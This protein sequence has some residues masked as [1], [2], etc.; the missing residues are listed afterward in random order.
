MYGVIALSQAGVPILLYYAFKQA[1]LNKLKRNTA[2]KWAWYI[3]LWGGLAVFGP[4]VILWPFSYLGIGNL[5]VWAFDT[6]GVIGILLNLIVPSLFWYAC[7]MYLYESD[8]KL[9]TVE[10]EMYSYVG[11]V[12]MVLWVL[13]LSLRNDFYAYYANAASSVK[14]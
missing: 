10:A 8:L 5:Y 12:W 14:L 7:Q 13:K 3:M 4:L 1:V 2:Y 6:L 11:A 9:W